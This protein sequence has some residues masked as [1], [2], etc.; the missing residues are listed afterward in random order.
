[1]HHFTF[2]KIVAQNEKM[3]CDAHTNNEKMRQFNV[4]M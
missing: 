2:F 4:N 3:R 1:M